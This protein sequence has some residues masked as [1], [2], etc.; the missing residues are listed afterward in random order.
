[1][2]RKV[3]ISILGTSFYEKCKYQNANFLSQEVRFVQ[4]AILQN[5]GANKWTQEDVGII[6][7]TNKARNENWNK[8][9]KHRQKFGVEQ[10]HEYETLETRIAKLNLAIRIET[11]AIPDGKSEVEMWEI[12]RILFDLIQEEDELYFDLTHSFRYLPMLLLVFG[13]YVKFL[14]KVKVIHISY[15]NYEARDIDTNVA[16]IIDLLPISALQDWTFASA[17]Y[18][19]N[20]VVSRLVELC[21]SE[22]K[23]ILIETKGKDDNVKNLQRFIVSLNKVVEERINCRG[24]SI[25]NSENM[26]VLKHTSRKLGNTFIEPLNPIFDKIKNSLDDFDENENVNNGFAAVKWCLDFELYQ[27]ATTILNENIITF[28]CSK[29]GLNWKVEAER[30]LVNTAFNVKE[31]P[32]DESVWKI[33]NKEIQTPER[34]VLI[35]KVKALMQTTEVEKLSKLFIAL[36]DLR[37]DYNHA[38]M[39]NN[40]M[41]ADSLRKSLIEKYE[42]II[43]LIS[44]C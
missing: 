10:E 14:K 25:V 6:L 8:E 3:F 27:Q 40:P 35:N 28:V 22:L 7:L 20:G 4:E 12:F 24:V 13:N 23:P 19:E 34:E 17:N 16:P 11:P 44:P 39:R 26:R 36:T 42:S 15:G 2:G 43:K 18:L 30:L 29:N 9:I 5:I 1:M 38:G 37:N 33:S 31:K 21:T 32:I 41:S